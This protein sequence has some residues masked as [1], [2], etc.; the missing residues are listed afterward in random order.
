MYVMSDDVISRSHCISIR[1]C[2]IFRVISSAAMG[3]AFAAGKD[4]MALITA[5]TEMTRPV[6]MAPVPG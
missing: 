1:F 4:A 2:H 5:A 3:I 6:V